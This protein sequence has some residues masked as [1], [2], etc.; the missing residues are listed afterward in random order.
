MPLQIEPH[1]SKDNLK[2]KRAFVQ[3]EQLMQIK[4]KAV[5]FWLGLFCVCCYNSCFEIALFS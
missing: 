5:L 3:L 1:V 2:Q 4:L